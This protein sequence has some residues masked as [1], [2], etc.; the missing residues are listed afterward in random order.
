[1][2]DGLSEI[3]FAEGLDRFLL[4]CP[5]GSVR[6]GVRRRSSEP[7]PDQQPHHDKTTPDRKEEEG[8]D[9]RILRFGLHEPFDYADGR[10]QADPAAGKAQEQGD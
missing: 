3:F 1:L 8:Q 5:T 6:R 9:S 2:P 4:I 7:P 10:E